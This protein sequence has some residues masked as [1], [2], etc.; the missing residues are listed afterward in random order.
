MGRY[1]DRGA[2]RIGSNES[3]KKTAP[4]LKDEAVA[5]LGDAGRC[6]PARRA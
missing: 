5:L 1:E 2:A 4:S 3:I 6:D